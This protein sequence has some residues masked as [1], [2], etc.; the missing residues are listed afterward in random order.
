MTIQPGLPILASD[1]LVISA[2]ATSALG[3]ANQAITTANAASADAAAALALAEEAIAAKVGVLVQSYTTNDATSF[4]AT[5]LPAVP[6]TGG[7]ILLTG[8]ICATRTD[9]FDVAQWTLNLLVNRIDG[10]SNT[11][12]KGDSTPS[13]FYQ[14]SDMATTAVI[15][16]NNNTGPQ[17]I[18]QGI[19]GV[20]IL[21]ALNLNVVSIA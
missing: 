2:T 16:S 5:G 3:V 18:L 12:I 13:I 14:D 19:D 6:S 8:Q 15:L 10:E 4:N 20:N 17:I 21:W 11:N 9:N 7:V 1:V